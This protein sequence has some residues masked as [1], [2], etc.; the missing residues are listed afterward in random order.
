MA[1]FA[2]AS[3][4]TTT[5][6][7]YFGGG[8]D[9][10]NAARDQRAGGRAAQAPLEVLPPPPRLPL[11]E[12]FVGVFLGGIGSGRVTS[13]DGSINCASDCFNDMT[14][15][16]GRGQMITLTAT[17][18][19]GSAFAGWGG[20]CAGIGPTC[21]VTV[22][23]LQFTGAYA[24]FTSTG[25]TLA[26]GAYHTCLLQ[27]GAVFCW[28]RNTDGQLGIGAT[29]SFLPPTMV[30]GITTAVAIAAGGY[31]TCALL[32]GGT[33]MCWGNNDHG[34]L[35]VGTNISSPPRLSFPVSPTPWR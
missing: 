35:G 9:G 26:A 17:P 29:S 31:H 18:T 2:G 13:S 25:R 14:R 11:V 3:D 15:R 30:P 4:E 5:G 28:G 8:I 34:Q 24:Y 12:S 7:C 27:S 16:L 32:A 21:V 20:D 6:A 10:R 22:K 33:V 23:P 1:L 19:P